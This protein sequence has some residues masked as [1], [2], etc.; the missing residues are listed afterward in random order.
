MPLLCSFALVL[1]PTPTAVVVG[2]W[3]YFL[4]PSAAYSNTQAQGRCYQFGAELA[5]IA[6][7]ETR[8]ER[9]HTSRSCERAGWDMF[10][11][12]VYY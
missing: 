11:C 10:A 12:P 1:S 8:G 9:A 4:D 5:P 2:K 6:R 7:R 3:L